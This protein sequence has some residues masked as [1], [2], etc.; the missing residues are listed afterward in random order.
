MNKEDKSQP[1]SKKK[2]RNSSGNA[3]AGS[4]ESSS[5]VA[6]GLVKRNK[7]YCVCKTKYDPTK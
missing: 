3:N 7:T 2:K 1:P 5:A 6:K 4:N